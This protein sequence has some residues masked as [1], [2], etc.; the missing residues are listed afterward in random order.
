M[1]RRCIIFLPEVGYLLQD[2]FPF[3]ERE[4]TKLGTCTKRFSFS[5]VHDAIILKN[6]TS[7]LETFLNN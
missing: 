1:E 4:T 5:H 2:G 3:I 7:Y 6:G